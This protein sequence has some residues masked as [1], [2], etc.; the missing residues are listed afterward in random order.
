M[1]ATMDWANLLD[2]VGEFVKDIAV[3]AG[4][5][6]FGAGVV[7]TFE[8]VVARMRGQRRRKV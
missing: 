1:E 8:R 7:L 5:V 6:A 4:I 2:K 3:L